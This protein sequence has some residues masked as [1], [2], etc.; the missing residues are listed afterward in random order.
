MNCGIVSALN[1]AFFRNAG[2]RSRYIQLGDH[3]VSEASWDDGETWHLFDS[4]MSVYCFNHEGAVASCEEI[5]SSAGC[6]LSGG[7][8]EP[9]HFYL[10]HYAPPCGTHPKGWRYCSDD[11][12][13]YERT[14][15]DGAS[16]YTDG[17]SVQGFSRYAQYGRRY[18]LNLRPC[19]RYTRHYEPLDDAAKGGDLK[20]DD[21][22]YYRPL[23]GKDPDDQH[24]LNN[25]RGNGV[26]V[27]SPELSG[28]DAR[29]LAYDES[30]VEWRASPPYVRP[31][32][33]GP[34]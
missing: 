25:I 13:G 24:G 28:R 12:V 29:L 19:E 11:P 30:G 17:F 3:T 14:L 32:R 22:D 18:I 26:W 8:E 27:F 16:S 15:E 1:C 34:R 10:Y 4:S 31:S 21:P 6:E 33:P 2:M 5:K 9:G 7:R 23:G 20:A